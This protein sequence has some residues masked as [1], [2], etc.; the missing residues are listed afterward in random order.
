LGLNYRFYKNFYVGLGYRY[1]N[2]QISDKKLRSNPKEQLNADI[3]QYGVYGELSYFINLGEMFTLEA[4]IQAGENNIFITS[5]P[6]SNLG[7]K[8]IAKKGLFYSPNVIIYLRGEESLS[9]NLTIGYT[10]TNN[11][12]KPEDVCKTEFK[13]YETVNFEPSYQYI[14][15]GFGIAYSFQKN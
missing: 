12:F 13:D 2:F 14:N 5:T 4:N 3:H 11:N 1:S 10:F 15:V 8:G 7:E 9:F 6:C